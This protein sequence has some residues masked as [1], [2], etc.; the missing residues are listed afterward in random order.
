MCLLVFH[1]LLLSFTVLCYLFTSKWNK[2]GT[3]KESHIPRFLKRKNK[4]GWSYTATIRIKGYPSASRTF[5]TKGEAAAWATKTEESIRL[6][7]YNDPRQALNISLGQ[8]LE[9]YL[10]TISSK[11]AINT[12]MR[13]KVAAK[14]LMELIGTK[15]PLGTILPATVAT[16]RDARL[17]VVS[18][19]P[20][21]QELSL[22]SH[23]FTFA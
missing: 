23:L 12:H 1:W 9:K 20:V 11:K 8:A 10:N 19:Y 5:D 2:N 6:K 14:R 17:E 4:K 16:Y 18:A 3:K 15:S 22:L 13:E 21:R 7:K